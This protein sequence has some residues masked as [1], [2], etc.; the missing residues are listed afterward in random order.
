MSDKLKQI[1]S[2]QNQKQDDKVDRSEEIVQLA[3][4]S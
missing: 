2:K 4:L 3:D 1:I